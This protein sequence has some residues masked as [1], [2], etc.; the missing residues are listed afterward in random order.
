[1]ALRVVQ[2]MWAFKF[3]QNIE[4]KDLLIMELKNTGA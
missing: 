1:M 4:R 3:L 2:N